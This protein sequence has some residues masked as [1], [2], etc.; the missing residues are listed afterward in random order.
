MNILDFC[1]APAVDRLVVVADS[2]D[3]VVC[4]G[5]EA[6][7][8]VLDG[9]G[10]L[11]LVDQDVGEA[12]LVVTEDIRTLAQQLQRLEQQ[13]GE[14]EQ[15]RACA[16]LLVL[17]IDRDHLVREEIAAAVQVVRP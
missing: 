13:I 8:G 7:P 4:A 16:L 12:S 11:K 5:Q 6:Q 2:K 14:V 17:T 10:V 3:I 15:T 1:A 9:V